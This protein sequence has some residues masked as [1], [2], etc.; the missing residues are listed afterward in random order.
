MERGLLASRAAI[1]QALDRPG[2]GQEIIARLAARS[3]GAVRLQCGS[4]YPTLRRLEREGRVRGWVERR[5]RGRP[6]RNYELTVTGVVEADRIAT[7]LRSLLPAR[8]VAPA[9]QDLRA[10]AARIDACE[11]ISRRA[12]EVR[13]A[14]P[15]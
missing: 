1:L 13:N 7:A 6:R 9:P 15:R 3:K 2:S 14:G 5:G 8:R 10:M 11:V 12:R 4:V